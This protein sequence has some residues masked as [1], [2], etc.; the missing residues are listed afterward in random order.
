MEYLWIRIGDAGDYTPFG[1]LQEAAYHL[2]MLR[3]GKVTGWWS[4]PFAVGFETENYHRDDCVSC[5]WGNEFGQYRRELD[6]GERAVIEDTL[7]EAY[8]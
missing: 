8:L 7:E 5:Y 1:S 4:S 6:P 2:N 3:V